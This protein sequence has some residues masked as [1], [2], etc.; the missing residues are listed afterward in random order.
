MDDRRKA[1]HRKD[2]PDVPPRGKVGIDQRPQRRE[3]MSM[4][5]IRLSRAVADA[6]VTTPAQY[7][8]AFPSHGGRVG[9][10]MIDHRHEHEIG[11]VIRERKRLCRRLPVDHVSSRGLAASLVQHLLRGIYADDLDPEMRRQQLGKTPC[12]AAEVDDQ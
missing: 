5:K 11:A 6:N 4:R 1:A 8:M 12:T 10:M 3:E 9:K 7:A 2:G